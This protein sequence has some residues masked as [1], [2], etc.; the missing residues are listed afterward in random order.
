M[1]SIV[2]V[3]N[4]PHLALSYH[5]SKILFTININPNT[6]NITFLIH[7][8]TIQQTIHTLSKFTHLYYLKNPSQQPLTTYP[9]PPTR[10][11]QSS[12]LE[13]SQVSPSQT[14]N[15][16]QAQNSLHHTATTLPRKEV[17][18]TTIPFHRR[19]S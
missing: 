9:Y 10:P 12:P 13:S 1:N 5:P 14:Q 17:S 19:K 7:H 3:C 15:Q 4:A 6:T 8:F 2:K 16:P 18:R 11:Q